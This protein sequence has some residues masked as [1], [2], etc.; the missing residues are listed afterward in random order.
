MPCRRYKCGYQ[1]HRI[2]EISVETGSRYGNVLNVEIPLI[3][4]QPLSFRSTLG[5]WLFFF[6]SATDW[7]IYD[8]FDS[9]G[10]KV[11]ILWGIYFLDII[12][13]FLTH[14]WES[15]PLNGFFT[16]G[17]GLSWSRHMFLSGFP[18]N[19][20]WAS[21]SEVFCLCPLN[22]SIWAI[23]NPKPRLRDVGL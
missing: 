3:K 5:H 7:F 21:L 19:Q 12:N 10:T 2:A 11:G 22:R 16:S 8:I 9:Y 15:D 4:L 14:L 6:P 1:C 20:Q 17:H 18:D 13:D 23:T